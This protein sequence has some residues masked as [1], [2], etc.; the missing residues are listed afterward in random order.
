MPLLPYCAMAEPLIFEAVGLEPVPENFLKS[1][2]I[3]CAINMRFWQ[4]IRKEQLRP[5][6]SVDKNIKFSSNLYKR[7][8]NTVRTPG[9]EMD[10]IISYFKTEK[11]GHCPS[12]VLVI[13]KGRIF[14]IDGL[15][16]DG[17]L[18]APQDFLLCFQQITHKVDSENVIDT[19][20]P[21]LTADDRTSW[22]R[23]RT[24]LLELSE[25]NKNTLME[26]ESA[27]SV[28]S[29]DTNCP[30]DHSEVAAITLAGDLHSRWADKSSTTVCFQNG[31]MGCF[32]E[33][34]CYDGTISVSMC[35]Y[36][37]LSIFEDGIP[38]WSVPARQFLQPKELLFDLDDEIRAEIIRMK[39]VADKVVVTF[40][41][42]C[43]VI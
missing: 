22:A 38:D 4:L 2:A 29:L 31:R 10:K 12:H 32:G 11:E 36:V 18:L 35:L 3:C 5:I 14:K 15:H 13:Y 19:D 17:Q 40:S 43:L 8:F 23:N 34:S 39:D 27:I 37:M 21:V 30:N 7:L 6:V 16:E 24:H 41:I 1:A 20:I 33:H 42:I 28:F 26:V 9:M 25:N